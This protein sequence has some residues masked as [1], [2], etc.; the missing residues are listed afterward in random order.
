MLSLT[1][2]DCDINFTK[3]SRANTINGDS[4]NLKQI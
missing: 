2:N 4:D 1:D 3:N